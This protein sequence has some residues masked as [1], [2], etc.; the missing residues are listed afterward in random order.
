MRLE[1]ERAPDLSDHR[2]THPRLLGHGPRA[3]VGLA[4]GLGLESPDDDGLDLLVGDRAGRANAGLVIQ[5]IETHFDKP[6][7]PLSDSLI[8]GSM[9]PGDVRVRQ[10]VCAGKDHA[11]AEGNLPIDLCPSRAA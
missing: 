5:A 4:L 3:P 7:S 9:K 6:P 10:P 11:R 2:V 1:T 8:G